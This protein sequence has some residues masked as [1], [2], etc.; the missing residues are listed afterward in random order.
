MWFTA[1]LLVSFVLAGLIRLQPPTRVL[2]EVSLGWFL[3][4]GLVVSPMGCMMMA[5]LWRQYGLRCCQLR[6][7]CVPDSMLMHGCCCV[8]RV[9]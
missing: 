9:C 5:G 4:A 2:D 6:V 1:R 8:R 3:S 7:L